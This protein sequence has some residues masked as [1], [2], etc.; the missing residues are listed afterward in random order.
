M[1]SGFFKTL[2]ERFN[3][4]WFVMAL[5]LGGTSVAGFAVLNFAFPHKTTFSHPLVLAAVGLFLVADVVVIAWLASRQY[6]A[7][8]SR[9]RKP[10]EEFSLAESAAEP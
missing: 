1:T 7:L 8:I 5:G 10:E 6:M 2:V 9:S 4:L 3:M